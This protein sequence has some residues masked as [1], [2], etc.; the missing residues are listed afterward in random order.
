MIPPRLFAGDEELGKKDDDHKMHPKSPFGMWQSSRRAPHRRSMKRAAVVGIVLICLY[1]FFKNMPTDL[2]NPRR[3]PSYTHGESDPAPAKSGSKTGAL[4]LVEAQ[5]FEG[6]IKFY[7]LASTLHALVKV[8]GDEP[9]NDNV[10][11]AAASLKSASTLLPVA[12]EMSLK[13]RNNVHFAFMS[14]DEISM[15]ILKAVNGVGDGCGILF[16]DAR[17]DFGPRSSEFRMT[18]SSSAALN[19]IHNFMHPQVIIIDGSGNEEAFFLK[20]VRDR[21]AVINRPII[22][23]PKDSEQSLLWI[24]ELD[25]VSLEAWNKVHFDILIHAQ[26]GASGS[27]IRLLESLKKADY[28]GS[29]VPRLTIELPEKIDEPTRRY[30]EN[31]DWPPRKIAPPGSTSQLSLHHRIP[32]QGLSPEESSIRFL[33][34]FWPARAASSHIL[35]LSPQ[36]ELSPLYF[37]YLKF[38]T[39][40]Y[41]HSQ[42]QTDVNKRLLGISLDLP[43]TYLNDSTPFTPPP[44]PHTNKDTDGASPFLWQAPN[45][46]AALYFGERWVELHEFVT[47]I[48][49]AERALPPPATLGQK[50]VSKTFPSWLE[51]IL[52][53]ARARGY[54][55]LYP[56][57]DRGESMATTHNELYQI[58]EEFPEEAEEFARIDADTELTAD[59]SY[60]LSLKHEEKPLSTGSLLKFLNG[61][62]PRVLEMPVLNWDGDEIAIMDIINN[63]EAYSKIF[64]QEIGGCG[65]EVPEKERFGFSA[66]DLFCLHDVIEA[67]EN[68]K[69]AAAAGEVKT[70]FI[71]TDLA[72]VRPTDTPVLVVGAG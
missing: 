35:V 66:R 32:E 14:R 61:I 42:A 7:K 64:R 48:L 55:M 6:P 5:D 69:A 2:E 72:A 25:C 19:H 49:L 28:F 40:E 71:A 34:A 51:H 43:S 23:L 29:P 38:M 50:L 53:L 44:Q 1:Y 65:P 57:F 33:E 10:L 21:A 20:G 46:N 13:Q 39:L 63:A 37:H 70:T 12:C 58:P 8:H 3:R 36:A 54:W 47:N 60:H 17:P 59:P 27:L 41:K 62:L 26:P 18:V 16:H 11:F 68:A 31:Y 52:K 30:L 24:T 4:A 45:S 9:R 67:T 22:E 15:D 56:N